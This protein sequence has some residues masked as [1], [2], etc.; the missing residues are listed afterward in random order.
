[1]WGASFGAVGEDRVNDVVLV[2]AL[3]GEGT[4]DLAELCSNRLTST[5]RLRTI[6]LNVSDGAR[7]A[8]VHAHGRVVE[9]TSD[10]ETVTLSVRMSDEDFGR[11]SARWA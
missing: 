7:I 4:D 11:F 6:N 9:Q 3:T 1:M 2:S 10:G 8:W 5:Y